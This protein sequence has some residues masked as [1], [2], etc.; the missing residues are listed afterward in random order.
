MIPFN[1]RLNLFHT[2]L[3]YD[4]ENYFR[5]HDVNPLAAAL[6]L[7]AGYL[8]VKVKRGQIV[9]DAYQALHAAG[10]ALKGA[11]KIE[12]ISEYGMIEA[13]IDGGGLFKEFMDAFGK[14]AFDPAFGLFQPTSHQ[15]LT[16][17][18]DSAVLCTASI[19]PTATAA[20]TTAINEDVDGND[21]AI[22]QFDEEEEEEEEDH[23]ADDNNVISNVGISSTDSITSSSDK[24]SNSNNSNHLKYFRLVGMMLGKAIY[25]VSNIA[26]TIILLYLPLY[27]VS[28]YLLY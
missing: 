12:F 28:E 21:M 1:L 19:L 11:V 17:D 6:G 27:V 7:R 22:Q 4:K 23:S 8:R 13:G 26:T 15:L 25:E 5:H 10:D 14:A 18:P 9:Q 3:E 16:P 2:Y 20:A 24:S